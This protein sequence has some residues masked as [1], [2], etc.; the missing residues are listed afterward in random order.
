MA[1]AP[2][3]LRRFE[4]PYAR[5]R[6]RAARA[7]TPKPIAI[8]VPGSGTALSEKAWFRWG[9]SAEPDPTATLFVPRLGGVV[10]K[11]HRPVVPWR[12]RMRRTP[13]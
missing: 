3:R 1:G 2:S 4:G 10:V 9:V 11:N 13:S 5:R 7:A 12:L 8:I 6:R